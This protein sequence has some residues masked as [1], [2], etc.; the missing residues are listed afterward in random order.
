MPPKVNKVE[1]ELKKLTKLDGNKICA[2]CPEKMPGYAEMTH[3]IFIWYYLLM[4]LM[5]ELFFEVL[6]TS[7]PNARVFIVTFNSK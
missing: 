3:C 7:V 2:N 5:P 4:F 1:V 6:I